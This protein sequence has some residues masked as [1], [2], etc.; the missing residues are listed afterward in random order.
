MI[1]LSVII[2]QLQSHLSC[3]WNQGLANFGSQRAW[4]GEKI[5]YATFHWIYPLLIEDS[6]K[7]LKQASKSKPN[8]QLNK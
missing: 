4:L 5:S 1:L 8:K 7:L 6:D 2:S 3:E